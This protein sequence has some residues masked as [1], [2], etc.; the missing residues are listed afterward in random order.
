MNI[1]I[2]FSIFELISVPNFIN[3]A[4]KFFVLTGFIRK[5]VRKTSLLFLGLSEKSYDKV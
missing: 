3:D 1:T 2:E 5:C 4:I